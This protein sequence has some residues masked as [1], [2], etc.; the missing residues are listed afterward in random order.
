MLSTKS[1]QLHDDF[2]KITRG[3]IIIVMEKEQ[4]N[5]ILYYEELQSMISMYMYIYV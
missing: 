1:G 3:N 4:L 5:V 2:G